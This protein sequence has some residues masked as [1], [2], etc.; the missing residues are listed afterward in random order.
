MKDEY[1]VFRIERNDG[2]GYKYGIYNK[3]QEK[4]AMN[5]V[6]KGTFEE[7]K[8]K[9][10]EMINNLNQEEVVGHYYRYDEDE[11]Y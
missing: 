6:F 11:D 5:I 4:W 3:E 9:Q 1:F 2:K 7:C 8:T 10:L